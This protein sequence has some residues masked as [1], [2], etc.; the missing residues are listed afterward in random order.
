MA[1]LIA[2]A[3]PKVMDILGDVFA[4]AFPDSAEREQKRLE[5]SIQLQQTLNQ[6]D[7]AQMEINKTEATSA[8]MFVAGWR[9]FI[10]WVCGFAFA[11]NLIVQPFMQFTLSAAGYPPSELPELDGELLGWAMGGMLGLGTMRTVEKIKGVTTG[12]TGLPWHKK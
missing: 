4:T 9:P 7:L 1:P 12:L 8:S 2:A 3:L 6:L 5:F 10:G 11:Y